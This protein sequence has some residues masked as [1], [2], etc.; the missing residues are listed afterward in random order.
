[1]TD[2][3]TQIIEEFRANA[4]RVGGNWEGR[5]LL[6]LTTT[7]RKSGK[8]FTTPIMV[9]RD[10][11]RLLV[12]ASQ[13]GAPDHPDWFL[14]ILADPHVVVEVGDERYPAI[15]TPLEGDERDREYAAQA[16]RYPQFAEYQEKTDR[17]I[18]VVALERDAG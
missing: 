13:A 14:N 9:T 16:E 6:L 1:M 12:Y 18:P 15:A 11:D 10:G 2:Y 8:Q 4:G 3:N 5:D 17:V 7:G